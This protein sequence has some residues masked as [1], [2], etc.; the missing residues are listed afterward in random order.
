MFRLPVMITGMLLC[1]LIPRFSSAQSAFNIGYGAG[2]LTHAAHNLEVV[3][4]LENEVLHPYWDK[5]ISIN[6][7]VHG[8]V[9]GFSNSFGKGELFVFYENKHGV[10]SGGGKNPTTGYDEHFSYKL[11]ITHLSFGG[12]YGEWLRV[13]ASLDLGRFKPFWKY[14]LGAQKTD[15]YELMYGKTRGVFSKYLAMGSSVII[16]A[17]SDSRIVPRITWYSDWFGNAI[18]YGNNSFYYRSSTVSLDLL[19]RIGKK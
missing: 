6:R 10:Y 13:G 11:K 14:D 9:F 3:A 1:M 16:Q 2:M 15:G 7:F 12:L 4:F 8:P 19:V 18:D 5:K 17:F